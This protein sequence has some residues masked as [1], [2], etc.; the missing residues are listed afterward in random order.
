MNFFKKNLNKKTKIFSFFYSEKASS[1]AG[2]AVSA[3]LL[4]LKQ[5]LLF[6]FTLFNLEPTFYLNLCLFELRS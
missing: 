1:K 6:E 3:S 2:N 4:V 5:H